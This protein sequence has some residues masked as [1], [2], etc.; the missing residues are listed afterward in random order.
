MTGMREFEIIL[1][2]M[3]NYFLYSMPPL[4]LKRVPVFSK[5]VIGVNSLLTFILGYG[6]FTGQTMVPIVFP[7]FFLV[8]LAASAN[9][10]DLKDRDGDIAAGIKTLPVIVGMPLAQKFIG[11]AFFLTYLAAYAVFSL[12]GCFWIC[13]GAGALQ[14]VL[15]NRRDYD[16]RLVLAVHVLSLL[17]IL[18]YTILMPH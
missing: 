2:F 6:F 15:V 4:R 16:E 3:A 9:F 7:V 18:G 1:V 10:I 14:F 5:L 13:L 8:F 11:G 12:A 17:F